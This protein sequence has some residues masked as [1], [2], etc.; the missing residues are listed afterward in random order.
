MT[1]GDI[2]V[3]TTPNFRRVG[4]CT[5]YLLAHWAPNAYLWDDMSA[6][7][8]STEKEEKREERD[9]EEGGGKERGG[10]K[11]KNR[12]H[13]VRRKFPVNTP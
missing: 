1:L 6:H 5:S 12:G 10:E 3:N 2:S 4:T 8:W 9:G 7:P 13:H 11:K